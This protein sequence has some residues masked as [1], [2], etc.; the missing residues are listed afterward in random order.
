V[1][2]DTLLVERRGPVA[3]VTLNRPEK[4][5]A[6]NDAMM[7]DF[8]RAFPALDTDPEV[9]AIV[10]T[11][12]GRAY[13]AGADI[14][15]LGDRVV[16]RREGRQR[17]ILNWAEMMHSLQT[18]TICAFNGLAVGAGLS[19]SLSCDIRIASTEA[20]FAMSFVRVGIVP[21][22]ASTHLLPQIVGLHA[23]TELM[24]TGRM[25]DAQEAFR[26]GL[27]LKVVEPGRLIDEA[28]AIG[29]T[30]ADNPPSAIRAVKDLIRANASEPDWAAVRERE[31]AAIQ[32]ALGSPESLEA[33]AAFREKRKPNFRG[34]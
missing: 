32:K 12:A 26:I 3:I 14:G 33:M 6:W 11:G 34:L 22:L 24:L 7:D 18:P 9:A 29:A 28:V 5:N 31:R 19:S 13:C 25:I 17:E 4:L 20:R 1:T 27:V 8:A 10:I 21:E 2:Y 16:E 23:A 30:I 15:A